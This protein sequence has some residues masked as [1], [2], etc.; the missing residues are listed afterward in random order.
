MQEEG[1]VQLSIICAR[2]LKIAARR[3]HDGHDRLSPRHGR[4]V[5]EGLQIYT[6][7]VWGAQLYAQ[8][9]Q[10]PRRAL[11]TAT[12]SIAEV[13]VRSHPCGSATKKQSKAASQP[14]QASVDDIQTAADADAEI[15]QAKDAIE[16]PVPSI[17][18]QMQGERAR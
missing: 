4:A 10:T 9:R 8:K 12:L 13:S 5:I 6:I 1:G 18:E 7:P 2:G 3:G 16:T 15:E 17:G 11:L 14:L